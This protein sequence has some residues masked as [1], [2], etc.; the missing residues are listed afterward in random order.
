M[1]EGPG[2]RRTEDRGCACCRRD[3]EVSPPYPYIGRAQVKVE[4]I[5]G[6]DWTKVAMERSMEILNE[7]QIWYRD[8]RIKSS[9][10]YR[11]PMQYRKGMGMAA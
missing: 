1:D 10:G 6:C 4:F 11:S 8:G 3:G 7:H 9:L 2:K 5:Y